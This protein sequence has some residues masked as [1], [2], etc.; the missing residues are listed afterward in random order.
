[1]AEAPDGTLYAATG[2]RGRVY[3]IGRDGTSSLLWTA[4]QPEVFAI[5]VGHDGAVYAGS[6]P[7]GKVY[8]IRNGQ[9]EEYFAP[10]ARYIWSLAV[11][12][13]GALYVGTGDQGKI[14][15]VEAA[16]KGE[17][18][19]DTGQ[20]HVTGMAVD[21]QGRLLAGTEPNGILYRISAKDKAFVLYNASLPEIRAIVPMPDGSVYAAA[22]GGSVAKL[23]QAANAGRAA[24][25]PASREP[26]STSITVEAQAAGPGGEI[27]PPTAKRARQ[28]QAPAAAAP[29]SARNSLRRSTSATWK[30]P[31][32]IAS[33]RTTPWKRSGVRRKRTSTTCSRWRSRFFSPPTWTAAFTAWRPTA[34]SPWSPRL[35]KRDHPP[36][37]FG[38][39]I[40]AA[41]ATWAAFSAW[42]TRPAHRRRVRSARCTMPAPPRAGAL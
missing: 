32:S 14:F 41:T 2:N 12:P 7:D 8:R 9:A 42:A 26:P 3:R 35:T 27:K 25:A 38:P 39:F 23:A 13:D 37:A 36:A 15:R 19:Y 21:G 22:L 31:R 34:A 11:A 33:I 1:V 40:L 16:G 4:D 6:S 28:P 30:N 20:S 10:H 17:L 18:Y 24:R 29:R 5:A